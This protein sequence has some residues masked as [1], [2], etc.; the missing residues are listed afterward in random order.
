[1]VDQNAGALGSLIPDADTRPRPALRPVIIAATAAA[2][3]GI[4]ALAYAAHVAVAR[5]GLIVALT[6]AIAGVV[7]AIAT[8]SRQ[9]RYERDALQSRSAE[10]V[11]YAHEV[12]RRIGDLE[13]ATELSDQMLCAVPADLLLIDAAYRIGPRYANELGELLGNDARTGESFLDML[14]RLLPDDTFAAAR[15]FLAALFAGRSGADDAPAAL[16][17]VEIG[18]TQPDGSGHRYVAFSFRRVGGGDGAGRVLVTV[19]DVTERTLRELRLRDS[20]AERTAQFEFALGML[21][22]SPAEVDGFIALACERLAAADRAL[23]ASDFISETATK[24]AVLH[25]RLDVVLQA[26]RAIGERAGAVRFERFER[27]ARD[28]ENTLAELKSRASLGGD[29]FLTIVIGLDALNSDLDDLQAL[30][31]TLPAIDATPRVAGVPRQETFAEQHDEPARA[32]VATVAPPEPD[33][34]VVAGVGALAKMLAAQLGK[35]VTVD[36]AGFDS[37]LLPASR[38]TVIEDVLVQLTRNSLTHGIES[39][40]EREAAHK[41]RVAT[42]EIRPAAS[43]SPGTFAFTFRDDGRGLDTVKIGQRAIEVGLLSA[44]RAPMLDESEVAALIFE[45]G[46]TTDAG[47]AYGAARGLGMS[48]VKSRVVDEC[49]GEIAIDSEAGRYCEISF[50]VPVAAA[51]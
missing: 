28:F 21:L 25:Q 15:D 24:T 27:Q 31:D 8:A 4:G 5:Q 2:L 7:A 17:A 43:D 26:V 44:E 3:A 46:F 19:Q 32:A 42:I 41:P 6:A 47:T 10:F 35:E 50:Q 16:G 36:A 23:K 18:A 37:R 34:D 11:G 39:P 20:A 14:R 51:V 40:D 49:G 12:N 9:A 48:I 29:D 30:R 33:D 13:A 1:M 22:A 45:P 38:R